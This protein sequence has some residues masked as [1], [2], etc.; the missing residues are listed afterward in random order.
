M[1]F[2]PEGRRRTRLLSAI[3]GERSEQLD[4]ALVLPTLD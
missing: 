2:V 4:T 1:L 3:R